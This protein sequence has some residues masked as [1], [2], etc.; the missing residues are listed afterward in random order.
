MNQNTEWLTRL[1]SAIDASELSDREIS[2]RAGIDLSYI[3][4]FRKKPV[5]PGVIKFLR[6]CDALEVSPV[7]ILSG[8]KITRT[9]EDLLKTFSKLNNEQQTSIIQFMSSIV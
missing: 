2:K 4:K 3:N 7:F 5:D 9:Q 6:I 8:I 1:L